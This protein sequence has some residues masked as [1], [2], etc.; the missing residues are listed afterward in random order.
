LG[1]GDYLQKISPPGKYDLYEPIR[2]LADLGPY[3]HLKR[4]LRLC[5]VH[6]ARNIQ[7]CTVSEDVK[8]AM[9]SLHGV[10]HKDG[11]E[12]TWKNTLDFIK[13][14]GNKAGE[15]PYFTWWQL[16]C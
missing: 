13:R 9:F 6:Y 16:S 1:I 4:I 14:E 8:N 12:A 3:E 10:L 15:G 11:S 7:K 2:L 5:F